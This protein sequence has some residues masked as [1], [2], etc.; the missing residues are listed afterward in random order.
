[1]KVTQERFLIASVSEKRFAFPLKD[2]TEVMETFLTY[3]MPKA[4]PEYLGVMNFHGTPVPVLDFDS[5]L[6]RCPAKESGT[7]LAL[8]AR[9]GSLAVRVDGIE[10]IVSGCIVASG[11]EHDWLSG[12]SVDIGQE[13]I[14]SPSL[15]RLVELLEDALQGAERKT[16]KP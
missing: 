15:E 9:I 2:I 14:P 13:K 7:I 4:P 16:L 11:S 5:F 10:K 12:T 6:H 3:P 1:M 8:D